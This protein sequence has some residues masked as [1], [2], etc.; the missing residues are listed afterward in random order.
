MTTYTRPVVNG[1]PTTGQTIKATHINEPVDFLFDTVLAGGITADQLASLAVTEGKIATAAVTQTKLEGTLPDGATLAAATLTADP[2]RTIVDLAY[3]KTGDTMMHDSTGGFTNADVNGVKT[4]I[5]TKYL[6]GSLNA[7]TTTNVA[8]GI[9]DALNKI[10]AVSVAAESDGDD[11]GF[12]VY[13]YRS[14]S[15]LNATYRTFFTATNI[16]IG[17]VGT[18]VESN[19]YLIKIDYEI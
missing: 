3:A 9:A 18:H 8:H 4:K 10:R 11:A 6:T 16:T 5:Y 15:G 13:D 17:T 12:L 7:G 2:D 19:R 1:T 14:G